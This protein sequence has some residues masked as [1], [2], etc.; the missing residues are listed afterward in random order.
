MTQWLDLTSTER[1]GPNPEFYM[2][3]NEQGN[4]HIEFDPIP[5]VTSATNNIELICQAQQDPLYFPAD[6][7]TGTVTATQGSELVVGV[8][9]TITEAMVGRFIKFTGGKYWYEIHSVQSAT[10]FSLV[11][12]VQE[13]SFS[14]VGFVIAEMQRSPEEFHMTPVWAAAMDYWLLPDLAKAKEF[15]KKYVRDTLFL[16]KK[17]QNKTRSQ[18]IPGTSISGVNVNQP[19]N[20]PSSLIG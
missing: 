10:E 14:G 16:Q 20:Y 18:V 12:N 19:M 17:Y 15:E 1:S 13:S 5:N 8:G 4:L 7:V 3:F 9:T 11:N 6:Y 2:V